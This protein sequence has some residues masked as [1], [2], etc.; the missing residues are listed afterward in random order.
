M[1][2]YQIFSI[3]RARRFLA[4]TIFLA[5]VGLAL[6]WIVLRPKNYTAVAPVLVDMRSDPVPGGNG[7]QGM[8]SPSFMAT[9]IDIVRSERV[10]QRAVQALHL[11]QQPDEISKWRSATGGKIAA[12]PWLANELQKKLDV[13]PARESHII[14]ITWTGH[15]RAEA[16]KVANAFAQSYLDVS[17]EL[18]TDPARGYATWFEDQVS[19]SRQKL[20]AAQ[21]RLADFQQKAGIV[22]TDERTDYETANLNALSAQ[23]TAVQGHTAITPS[24]GEATNPIV[25]NLRMDV[26]KLESK[27]RQGAASMG[28]RH[29]EMQKMQAEL[30][31]MRSM[32]ASETSRAGSSAASSRQSQ[33]AREKELRDAVEAQKTKVLAL[34]KQRGE[35]NLLQRD[36]E[37]AQKAYDAVTSSASQVRLQSMSNQTNVMPLAAAVEP[38][39]A[40]GLTGKVMLLIAIVAGA[41]LALAGALLAELMNR[42]VRTVDDLTLVTR[43][44]VLAS[45]PPAANSA[46]A[47]AYVALPLSGSRRLALSPRRSLA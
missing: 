46:F 12:V 26:A 41:L 20:E 21:N 37:A 39:D 7:L 13:K 25:N 16:A 1:S 32:L 43:L 14:N 34:S 2:L 4:G 5:I 11:D 31:S 44:P 33:L 40:S 23:L 17:L 3:L 15:S 42:R 28:E 8:M 24:G 38:I 45:V 19:A 22:S 36:V 47:N 6:V 27:I 10:A 29:P 9:Q 35:L 18:K 30:A